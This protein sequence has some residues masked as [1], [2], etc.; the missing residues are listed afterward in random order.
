MRH[1]S[2]DIVAL[3]QSGAT[4]LL[5]DPAA[6]MA[7]EVALRPDAAFVVTHPCH[8]PLFNDETSPEA[9]ADFFGGF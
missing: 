4:I 7:K 9:R 6:A 8:P 3:A 2:R 5:L 1:V